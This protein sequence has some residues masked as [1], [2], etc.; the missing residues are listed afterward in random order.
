MTTT[1]NTATDP[2]VYAEGAFRVAL[3]LIERGFAAMWTDQAA[4]GGVE[5]MGREDEKAATL[6]LFRLH[7]RFKLLYDKQ[8]TAE[9]M[10]EL[11]ARVGDA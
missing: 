11:L 4:T 10:E 3:D 9:T 1:E 7:D 2:Y 5:N 6:T 8:H